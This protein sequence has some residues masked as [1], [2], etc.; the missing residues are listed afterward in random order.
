MPR[1]PPSQAPTLSLALYYYS[2]NSIAGP[3][4]S[5]APFGSSS[6][7]LTKAD[8]FVNSTG[9]NSVSLPGNLSNPPTVTETFN[10]TSVATS[11]A[12]D[13]GFILGASGVVDLYGVKTSNPS[14]EATLTIEY[15]PLAVP[16]P[17]TLA[18]VFASLPTGLVVWLRRRPATSD[19][20]E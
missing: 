10:V 5:V 20:P 14:Y 15:T 16:E 13:I 12:P 19:E 11:G 18:L 6:P 4:L 3:S 8:F 2:G 7:T 17:S 9:V 1:V